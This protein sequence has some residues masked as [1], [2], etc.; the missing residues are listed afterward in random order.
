[1]RTKEQQK[2]YYKNRLKK[3]KDYCLSISRTDIEVIE[4]L[5]SLDRKKS[6][7]IIDLIKKDIQK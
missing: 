4:K 3:A 7:Y 6:S 2:T 1:M 5:D